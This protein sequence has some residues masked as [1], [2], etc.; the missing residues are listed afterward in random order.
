[1][2]TRRVDRSLGTIQRAS[3]FLRLSASLS[4]RGAACGRSAEDGPEQT[5]TICDCAVLKVIGC[6][7][8]GSQHD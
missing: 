1:M 8:F 3:S 6:F 5:P 4:E 7:R 2:R